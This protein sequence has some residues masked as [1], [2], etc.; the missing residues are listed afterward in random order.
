MRANEHE[1]ED[2][3]QTWAIRHPEL[4]IGLELPVHPAT[5]AAPAIDRARS[6][7]KR[8]D[9]LLA[10]RQLEDDW[11]GQGTPAP[12]VEVVDSAL[13]LALLLRRDG[14][15]APTGVVQGVNGDVLFDWQSP[16]GKYVEVEVNGPY[17]AD[18]FIQVPGQPMK[19]LR[20]ETQEP[21]EAAA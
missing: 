17:T 10:I 6:W 20:L 7:D 16:G 18:V 13:V 21:D 2:T 5:S 3:V 11:D 1:R 12:A 19:H 15:E 8:I 4:T 14:I 9:Q